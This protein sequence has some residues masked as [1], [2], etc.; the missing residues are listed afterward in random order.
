MVSTGLKGAAHNEA[1]TASKGRMVVTGFGINPSWQAVKE[2]PKNISGYDIE[3]HEFP[4]DYKIVSA[5]M[6]ELYAGERPACTI[7]VGVGHPDNIA[8]E[9]QA[10]NSGYVLKDIHNQAPPNGNAI[11]DVPDSEEVL[12]TSLDLGALKTSMTTKGWLHVCDSKDPGSFTYYISLHM[13]KTLGANNNT[14]STSDTSDASKINKGSDAAPGSRSNQD[15]VSL[16]VHVPPVGQPYSQQQLNE[17]LLHLIRDIA[18]QLNSRPE[19]QL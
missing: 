6:P 4:V 10:H 2:L 5:R 18:A 19:P 3:T 15:G 12:C 8:L 1:S 13:A 9:H 11:Q 14:G 7:H 16:F 17:A